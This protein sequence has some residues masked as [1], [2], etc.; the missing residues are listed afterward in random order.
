MEQ[1]I[2][3]G[4]E[5]AVA[6]EKRSG[7]KGQAWRRTH[8]G[9]P[10][11]GGGERKSA[12]RVSRGGFIVGGPLR[13]FR[14]LAFEQT[15]WT[16]KGKEVRC[17]EKQKALHIV[18][19]SAMGVFVAQGGVQLLGGKRAKH[20]PRD[21]Q[22]RTKDSRHGEKRSFALDDDQGG[23]IPRH[24]HFPPCLA[25][26]PIV[27]TGNQ[28]RISGAQH[29]KRP[30]RRAKKTKDDAE[31]T[32]SFES[33]ERFEP[34]I[35]GNAETEDK[36]SRERERKQA[37]SEKKACGGGRSLRSGETDGGFGC[38]AHQQAGGG[39]QNKERGEAKTEQPQ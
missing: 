32:H 34:E 22:T 21:E 29:R 26:E 13:E 28:K 7:E 35:A 36:E 20:A 39:I 12:A 14:P 23:G 2:D 8:A 18:E 30:S 9:D 11:Q 15:K 19:R 38:S 10:H 25:A 4:G 37:H 31:H 6:G 33:R 1:A 17:K 3:A 27:P 5:I 24:T 16:D